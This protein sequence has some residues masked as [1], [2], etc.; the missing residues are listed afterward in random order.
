M[1]YLQQGEISKA[2]PDLLASVSTKSE[3]STKASERDVFDL[4]CPILK[5][6]WS[7]WTRLS[8]WRKAKPWI[9]MAPTKKKRLLYP[10]SP[11]GKDYCR[12]FLLNCST[13]TNWVLP[14]EIINYLWAPES[15]KEAINLHS[16]YCTSTETITNKEVNIMALGLSSILNLGSKDDGSQ[17]SISTKKEW[18]SL[19]KYYCNRYTAPTYIM[20]S[21]SS[22]SSWITTIAIINDKIFFTGLKYISSLKGS[23]KTDPKTFKFLMNM[24]KLI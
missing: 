2:C 21:E 24:C 8:E 3:G 18:Q 7:T 6:K 16:A 23:S 13:D 17:K 11:L 20:P 22:S 19:K 12:P 9:H 4:W 5:K 15:K 10:N 14:K 1:L